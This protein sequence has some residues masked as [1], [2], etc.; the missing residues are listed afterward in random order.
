VGQRLRRGVVACHSDRNPLSAPDGSAVSGMVQ[1]RIVLLL[2]G[3][4]H[5]CVRSTPD[6]VEK[7]PQFPGADPQIKTA[8]RA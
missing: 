8:R 2:A 3:L 4:D 7:R 5:G 1:M 6:P